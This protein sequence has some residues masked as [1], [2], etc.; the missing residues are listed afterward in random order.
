[1][2]DLDYPRDRLEIVVVSDASSDA[3]DEIASSYADRGVRLLRLPERGGKVAAENFAAAAKTARVQR[4][5]YLGGLGE[6]AD[7]A[8]SPHLRSRHS[9]LAIAVLAVSLP[10]YSQ[11]TPIDNITIIGRAADAADVPGSAHVLDTE[12]LERVQH[13]ADVVIDVRHGVTA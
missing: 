1:M 13:E 4:I 8:L 5:V 3:T 7:P 12:A 11:D 2:L 6:E 10:A 9:A